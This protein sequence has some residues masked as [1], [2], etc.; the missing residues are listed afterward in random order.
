MDE[1]SCSDS[2]WQLL[3]ELREYAKAAFTDEG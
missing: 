3:W 1:T 2:W